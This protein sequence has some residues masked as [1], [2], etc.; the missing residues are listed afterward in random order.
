M[1]N[2][3]LGTIV[4]LAVGTVGAL[5]Y[6]HYLGDGKLLS[7][8]QSQLDAANAKLANLSQAKDQLQRENTGISSQVDQL[9]DTNATLK[10]QL[11]GAKTEPT[12]TV[13]SQVNPMALIG[14]I[15][16]MMRA[17]MQGQAR[18]LLLQTRLHLTPDQSAKIKAAM[19]ADGKARRELMQ[20]MFRNNGKIDPA[21]AAQ[22][23]TLDQTLATVLTPEQQAAYKQVQS[24]EQASRADT[25][26]TVQVDQMMPLLQ[27][28]DSQKDQVYNAIY[29]SQ[30]TAPDPMTLISNPN[31]VSIVTSQA[32]ATQTA[33]A[34][35]LT[36]DQ[37]ALYQQQGQAM[38]Q[39]GG[40]GRRGGGNGGNGGN[41]T[42]AN[43]S[44]AATTAAPAPAPAP[45][46]AQ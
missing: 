17:G 13:A 16:G 43:A 6:T 10:K 39:F 25:A 23:N 1:R 33:L 32:Q 37:M 40:F 15:R 3:I 35:V 26:A 28:S 38:P 4:G 36:P 11:D 5:A 20:Q 45:A 41:A 14:T 29:Q 21:A 24:D 2:A 34:K 8:L 44:A 42:G 31:A 22:A 30:M 19:D 9:I 18:M 27:L 46:T 12:E 7:D